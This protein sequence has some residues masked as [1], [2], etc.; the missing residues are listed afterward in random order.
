MPKFQLDGTFGV[1]LPGSYYSSYTHEELGGGFS[2]HALG[3]Q[4]LGTAEF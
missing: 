3:A 1:F 4:L 2:Q